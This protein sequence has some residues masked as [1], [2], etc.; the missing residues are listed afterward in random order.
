MGPEPYN[1]FDRWGWAGRMQLDAR[2]VGDRVKARRNELRWSQ[3]KLDQVADVGHGYTSK[4]EK[5]EVNP[6]VTQLRKYA[7][8][9]RVDLEELLRP[10]VSREELAEGE[11]AE[12]RE[13]MEIVKEV[14]PNLLAIG[15]VDRQAA[16]QIARM[17][18]NWNRELDR[19]HGASGAEGEPEDA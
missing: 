8:A 7:T 3:R 4:L 12:D 17:I 14:A 9:L 10:G 16:L 5:G 1:I 6:T 2:A 15:R 18:R 19:E 13:L 11:S